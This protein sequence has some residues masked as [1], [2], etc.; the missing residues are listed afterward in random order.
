MMAASSVLRVIGP[1]WSSDSASANTPY[2]LTRP[3]VGLRP[4]MPHAAAGKRMDPPVS[5]PS[6]PKH[7]P[8]AVATPEPLEEAPAHRSACHGFTGIS[9][10]GLYPPMAP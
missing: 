6:E 4:T 5:L 8:A 10:S 3:Q 7:S 9:R 2:R 1:T